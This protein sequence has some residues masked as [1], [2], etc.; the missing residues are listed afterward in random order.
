MHEILWRR[1][2]F[3]SGLEEKLSWEKIRKKWLLSEISK[4]DIYR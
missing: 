1:H 4:Y 2:K 3:L